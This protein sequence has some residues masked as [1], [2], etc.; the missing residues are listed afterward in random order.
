[1][2]DQVYMS[3]LFETHV[4]TNLYFWVRNGEGRLE[5]EKRAQS[6]N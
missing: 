5:M 3:T 6:E 4:A 1:M 2:F